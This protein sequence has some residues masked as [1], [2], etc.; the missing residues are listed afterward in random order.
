MGCTEV[1]CL[2]LDPSLLYCVFPPHTLGMFNSPEMQALLQQI[3]ENPQ[4]MQNVISAPYMRSM[5]QTLAQNPDF[6]AQVFSWHR[7]VLLGRELGVGGSH[8]WS[9]SSRARLPGSVS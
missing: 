3:S 9:N 4:L 6:A 8:L 2:Y 1:G 7:E 5:M